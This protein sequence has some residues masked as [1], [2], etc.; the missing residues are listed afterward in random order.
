MLRQHQQHRVDDV[1]LRGVRMLHRTLSEDITRTTRRRDAFAA[2]SAGSVERSSSLAQSRPLSASHMSKSSRRSP[3]TAH[4]HSS[5]S[6]GGHH[7]SF[8]PAVNVFVSALGLSATAGSSAGSGSEVCTNMKR[9]RSSGL[10]KSAP[11][12]SNLVSAF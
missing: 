6:E 2:A 8:K 1:S 5:R 12:L 3:I 9:L 4:Y 10:G 11:N 7:D